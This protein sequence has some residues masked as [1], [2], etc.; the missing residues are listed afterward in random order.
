MAELA[1]L[2]FVDAPPASGEWC[3]SCGAPATHGA[4]L[5]IHERGSHG[6][7]SRGMRI[8]AT[9]RRVLCESCAVELFTTVQKA[10]R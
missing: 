5:R 9:H 8:V 4:L 10:M 1:R 2:S 3:R 6:E 7:G